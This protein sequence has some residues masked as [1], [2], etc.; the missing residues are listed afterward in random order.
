MS[1]IEIYERRIQHLARQ[2][3]ITF[4]Q[5]LT[6]QMFYHEK[7][8]KDHGIQHL[9]WCHSMAYGISLSIKVICCILVPSLT[10]YELLTFLIFYFEKVKKQIKVVMY[11]FRIDA[12]RWKISK[13]EKVVINI[14]LA[15][16]FT[17]SEI[18]TFQMFDLEKWVTV[19][20]YNFRDD[21]IRWKGKVIVQ[22]FRNKYDCC[23]G[24]L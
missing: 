12:I 21:A 2:F 3:S 20:D 14:F 24:T 23:S 7:V 9:Q 15:L 11:N 1:N 8:G 13:S 4:Y 22:N 6:F 19:A 18:L 17:F 10:G 16:D 5:I